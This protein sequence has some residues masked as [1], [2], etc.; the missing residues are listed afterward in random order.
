MKLKRNLLNQNIKIC[1][2]TLFVTACVGLLF[3]S[4]YLNIL[5]QRRPSAH[6]VVVKGEHVTQFDSGI[7]SFTANDISLTVAADKD[8]YVRNNVKYR[9]V[10]GRLPGETAV[11]QVIPITG[12]S[13]YY[14]VF[15]VCAAAFLLSFGITSGFYRRRLTVEVIDPVSSLSVSAGRLADGE[16]DQP[17]GVFAAG[18]LGE[19]SA[20]VEALRVKLK[21]SLYCRSRYDDNRT[22]LLSSISH[23]LKTP[24]TAVRGYIE[25]VIDGVADTDEKKIIYLKKAIEK[26][27]L[28]SIMIDDLLYYSKL[29]LNQ[30]PF[31]MKKC[32]IAAFLSSA[33]AENVGSFE[34]EN[35]SV[36]FNNKLTDRVT[37]TI[38]EEKF[39]RVV[40]NIIDNARKYTSDGC[41]LNITV[42]ERNAAV[43]IEFTDNGDGISAE[44]LPHI[45]D[46]FYRA[47]A[48]RKVEGSSGLGLAI[49]KQITEGMGGR[50]WAV[51]EP[52]EGTS[53]RITLNKTGGSI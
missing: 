17:V 41:T 7:D 18:E 36:C 1:V 46:R 33:A 51:S 2:I 44:A 27:K 15:L 34:A 29:D 49:S 14:P 16:L 8:F 12:A 38:D 50:I 21:D 25:G 39:Q 10:S 42:S 28:I 47:D 20:A 53:I 31:N 43:L 6:F 3:S 4:M 24:V 45:F 23:D 35:K 11:I 9:L 52:G 19:L 40:Q 5:E 37:V 30:I 13:E 22:F 26:T 48:A 32:D